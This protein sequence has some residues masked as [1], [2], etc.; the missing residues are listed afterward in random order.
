MWALATAYRSLDR[1]P[2]HDRSWPTPPLFSGAEQRRYCE[3]N[4][5]CVGPADL[6][7]MSQTE[8]RV[9]L[10]RRHPGLDDVDW[11]R[12]HDRR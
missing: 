4:S 7:L 8:M 3:Q 12:E 2:A 11:K 6:R 1:D 5:R 10:A 9:L